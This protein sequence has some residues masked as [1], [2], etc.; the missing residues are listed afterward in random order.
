MSRRLR[1]VTAALVVG[2]ASVTVCAPTPAAAAEPVH[3]TGTTANGDW[4]LDVPAAFNGTLLVWSHG[5]SFTPVEGTNAPSPATREALLAQGYAL[6]G[7]SYAR[8]GAGWA[9]TDGVRAGIEAVSIAEKRIGAQRV[10]KVF[11]WGNSLG[12]L[13]TQTLAERRPG[14]VDGVAPLCGVLAGTNRNLDLALDVAVGVKRMFYPKLRL[15][16][17]ASRAGA[18]ANVD[19]ATKAI[20]ARLAD[21]ATQASSSG[22]ILALAAL[23]G[24]A[25]KTKTYGGGSTASSVGAATESVLTALT[26]ATVGRYDIEQRVGGNPSTNVKTDYLA[27]VTPAAT[28]RFTA[29]GFGPGLLRSFAQSLQTYGKRVS[30]DPAARRAAARL[31]NPTGDL[32]HPTLTMHTVYDPL[33]I[34]QNERVFARRVADHHD[35]GRLLQ[36]YV[37]P[38]SF[39]SAAPYGAGHCNFDTDQYVAVVRALDGWV[40]SGDRPTA[41]ALGQ[42]F[43]AHPGALDLN[44]KPALWPAR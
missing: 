35:S 10:S 7:S 16:G 24:T 17:F 28:A 1:L 32:S 6:V 2:M 20:T 9:V 31:G 37:Q 26:Y 44:Y 25:A 21:P 29:F 18:Q 19:A 3:A 42:M 36:L 13:I 11:A 40:S 23:S 5:Y 8:G 22:R 33:V 34:V 41:A 4:V 27:R 12:G 43:S 14:L 30:A 39:V 38:P 15:R